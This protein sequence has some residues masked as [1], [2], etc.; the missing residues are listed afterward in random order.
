MLNTVKLF[1]PLSLLLVV[2]ACATLN[3]DECQHANWR[4]IGYED[5]CKGYR[6]DHI[7]AHRSACAQYAVTPDMASYQS[8]YQE[9]LGVYCKPYNG[10]QLGLNGG[11]YTGVCSAALEPGFLSAYNTGKGIFSAQTELN[12]AKNHYKYTQDQINTLNKSLKDDENQLI[13]AANTAEK[14][15]AI[16]NDMKNLSAELERLSDQTRDIEASIDDLSH[17]LNHLKERSP[18]K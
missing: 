17:H 8:G 6:S 2:G 16:I 12:N 11:V 3:K 4:T 18:Y 14:R 1:I 7:G 15:L 13:V 10:Y 5:A 9:G